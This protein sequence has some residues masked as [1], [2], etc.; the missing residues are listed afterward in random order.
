METGKTIVLL[1]MRSLYES[2]YELLNQYYL[3]HG[4]KQYVEI[5]LG[6]HRVKCRVHDEFRL[7]VIAA[8]DV[9]IWSSWLCTTAPQEA[10]QPTVRHG[11]ARKLRQPRVIPINSSRVIPINSSLST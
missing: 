10:A 5:G 7:V 1:N 8:E 3:K 11:C 9:V 2:L 6:A 4:G